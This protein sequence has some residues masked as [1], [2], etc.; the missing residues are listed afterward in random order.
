MGTVVRPGGPNGEVPRPLRSFVSSWKLPRTRLHSVRNARGEYRPQRRNNGREPLRLHP[1]LCGFTAD[2]DCRLSCSEGLVVG[3]FAAQYDVGW[4]GIEVVGVAEYILGRGG[5]FGED[6]RTL[7][8][9][10]LLGGQ[11]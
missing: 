4:V 8:L 2:R 1:S 9:N 11:V 6:T 7:Q 5:I 10:E 3:G